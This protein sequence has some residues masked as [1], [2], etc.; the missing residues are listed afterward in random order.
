MEVLEDE[1]S[2]ASNSRL[3]SSG[4]NNRQQPTQKTVMDTI[5]PMVLASKAEVI[6]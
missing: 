2:S 6:Q 5:V 4:P 1:I 3:S